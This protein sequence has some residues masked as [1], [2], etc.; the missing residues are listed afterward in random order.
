[1]NKRRAKAMRREEDIG[2][3]TS[4]YGATATVRIRQTIAVAK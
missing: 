4:I 3:G 1:V 2:N